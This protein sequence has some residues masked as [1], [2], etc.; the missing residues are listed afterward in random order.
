MPPASLKSPLSGMLTSNAL[1]KGVTTETNY[2]TIMFINLWTVQLHTTSMPCI[3]IIS[4]FFDSKQV[5]NTL[6]GHN[7]LEHIKER[8]GGNQRMQENIWYI[9]PPC[10]GLK[11]KHLKCQLSLQFGCKEWFPQRTLY[12]TDFNLILNATWVKEV[13]SVAY[14]REMLTYEQLEHATKSG[15]SVWNRSGPIAQPIKLEH[16]DW[17]SRYMRS[18]LY[19]K[20]LTIQVI[21]PADSYTLI[22]GL[23]HEAFRLPT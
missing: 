1:K 5:Y 16:F 14:I 7:H 18:N 9:I 13:N 6:N 19:R 2:Y 20:W 12:V 3:N 21:I 10:Q 23:R 4:P 22:I 8:G 11:N 15:V 17:A